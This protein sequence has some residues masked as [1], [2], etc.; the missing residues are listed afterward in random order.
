MLPAAYHWTD[1]ADGAYLHFNAICVAVVRQGQVT[2][3][4][5]QRTHSGACGGTEQGKRYVERWIQ[6]RGSALPG[7]GKRR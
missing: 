2:I 1:T 7:G 4:F 5:E 6:A 3:T